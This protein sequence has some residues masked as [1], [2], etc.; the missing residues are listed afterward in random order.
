MS[1]HNRFFSL[2]LVIQRNFH[3][4]FPFYPNSSRTPKFKRDWN[5]HQENRL[6]L[7][8]IWF[9][10]WPAWMWTISL[11]V[12]VGLIEQSSN[13]K[14]CPLWTR[15]YWG[16]LKLFVFFTNR[17]KLV[18][19]IQLLVLNSLKI[20]QNYVHSLL[21]FLLLSCKHRKRERLNTEDYCTPW[22][23]HTKWATIQ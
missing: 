3:I 13:K 22:R 12:L 6:T 23:S 16:F 10:H 11:M 7:A 2:L 14:V 21:L 17:E 5:L 18:T 20:Q 1:K 8:P 19:L 15:V 4:A 9:P